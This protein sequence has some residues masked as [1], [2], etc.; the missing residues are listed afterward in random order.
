MVAIVVLEDEDMSIFPHRTYQ[1]L[2][3]ALKNK[4][5]FSYFNP[6]RLDFVAVRIPDYFNGKI[7]IMC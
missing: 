5:F 4:K 6:W 3:E 1:F 7:K 2:C